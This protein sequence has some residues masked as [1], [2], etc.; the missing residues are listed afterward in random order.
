MFV[1]LW[2][3]A[4]TSAAVMARRVSHFQA[5]GQFHIQISWLWDFARSYNKIGRL[6]RYQN[7]ALVVVAVWD[8]FYNINFIYVIVLIFIYPMKYH[9]G[10]WQMEHLPM[11][12][13]D[14]LTKSSVIISICYV[15]TILA[16]AI[17]WD[18][19]WLR[20]K[21]IQYPPSLL[22]DITLT[23]SPI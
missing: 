3:L 12:H 8:F 15:K 16:K 17:C 23:R 6:I 14:G 7:K 18:P 5:I 10:C 19:L 4:G 20:G 2:N 11:L 21:A 13:S 9:L 1:L 22:T